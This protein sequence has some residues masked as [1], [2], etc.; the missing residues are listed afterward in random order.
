MISVRDVVKTYEQSRALEGITLDVAR[1]EC[2]GVE[3]PAGSGKTTLL[4]ILGTLVAPTTGVVT[5][6]GLDAVAHPY[7]IRKRVAYAS[8][9]SVTRDR[10]RVDEYAR[11]IAESR[12]SRRNGARGADVAKALQRAALAPSASVESLQPGDRIALALSTALLGRPAVLL[13]DEPFHALD[14][15][16]RARFVEWFGEALES[17]TT[18]VV[19]TGDDADAR[20]LCQRVV[21]LERGRIS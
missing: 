19:A 7:E 3:G 17:G 18:L 4:R 21:R 14:G 16:R 11:F 15:P 8:T 1:G 6:D 10:L 9:N 13:L 2:L 12:T 5:V 20:T